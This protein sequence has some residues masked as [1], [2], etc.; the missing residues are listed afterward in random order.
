M[1]AV[2]CHQNELDTAN[3]FFVQCLEPSQPNKTPF[4]KLMTNMSQTKIKTAFTEELS[5]EMYV[6]CD[7]NP[8]AID[9]RNFSHL[10]DYNP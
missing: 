7:D 2:K 4:L 3:S 5:M 10:L 6:V 8:L 9:Y 1:C